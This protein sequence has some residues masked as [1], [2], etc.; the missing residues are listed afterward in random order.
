MQ[1]H[2]KLGFIFVGTHR[3][4]TLSS[5]YWSIFF[6]IALY[7]HVTF[8]SEEAAQELI[9]APVA[10]YGLIYDDLAL[11]KML[12][13]TA[14]HPYFL[15]LTCHALVNRANRET[16]NYLTIQDV[17]DVLDEMVE[18]GEA[19]FAFLWEQSSKREQ[20]VLAALSRLQDQEPTVTAIQITELLTERGVEMGLLEVGETLRR[21]ATRD[22]VHDIEGQP[23]RYE[24]KIELV[25][26]WV[27]RY[28][29]L[30]RVVEE[31]A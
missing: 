24:Y 28:K 9:V 4:E 21:L 29:A 15:Q 13:V 17:N 12:R 19:H 27:E 7:K 14:G 6:N 20:L 25:R 16:R 10:E 5:D 1:H 8:L 30:G 31:I 26:L 23:P 22:V 3:L 11:D 2:Q 18:L